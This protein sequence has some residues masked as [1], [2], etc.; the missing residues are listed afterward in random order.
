MSLKSIFEEPTSPARIEHVN[1]NVVDPK[2]TAD[3]LCR[4]FGWSIR[5]EDP[6][7][8]QGTT[9]HI[10]TKDDYVTLCSNPDVGHAKPLEKKA[11]ASLNHIAVVVVDDLKLIERRVVAE[12]LTPKNFADYA[13]GHRFYFEDFD[14]V[15]YE[16]VSYGAGRPGFWD[17]VRKMLSTM[18]RNSMV[19]K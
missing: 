15:K 11:A 10:G 17:E 3:S 9:V 4:I 16:V 6:S 19:T 8:Q 13:P 12:G 1:I 5:W 18:S 2:K 7:R 14:G